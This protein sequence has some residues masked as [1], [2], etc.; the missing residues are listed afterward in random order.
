MS[1]LLHNSGL[2]DSF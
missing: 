2:F 1:V